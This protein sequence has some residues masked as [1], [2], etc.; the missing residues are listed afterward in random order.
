MMKRPVAQTGV[1][2]PR[3][4]A[5]LA[6]SD[7]LSDTGTVEDQVLS[8]NK[9]FWRPSAL[10]DQVSAAGEVPPL[11]GVIC[12]QLS[13]CIAQKRTKPSPKHVLTHVTRALEPLR[14][15][16]VQQ[17]QLYQRIATAIWPKDHAS[18]P[19][20]LAFSRCRFSWYILSV[21]SLL[22]E[23]SRSCSIV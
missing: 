13:M 15:S 4:T 19:R 20:G 14:E 17:V 1:L 18:T 2:I 21:Y 22:C 7:R 9:C 12:C 3:G 16:S 23:A 5:C 10:G 6:S 11:Y 8:E